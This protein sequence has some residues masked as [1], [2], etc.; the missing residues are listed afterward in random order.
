MLH[1]KSVVVFVLTWCR[2][3]FGVGVQE[4]IVAELHRAEESSFSY[5]ESIP[6]QLFHRAKLLCKR[7]KY[8]TINEWSICIREND[9]KTL[10]SYKMVR[11]CVVC[12]VIV[13]V[14]LLCLADFFAAVRV[15]FAESGTFDVY[16]C[17]VC[18][19]LLTRRWMHSICCCMIS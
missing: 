9:A 2:A 11:A 17:F 5:M 8:P 10:T 16:V 4:D 3:S 7:D 6:K 18:C 1:A 12:V 13:C 19:L 15:R 14:C